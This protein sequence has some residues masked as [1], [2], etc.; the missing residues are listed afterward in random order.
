MVNRLTEFIA[1]TKGISTSRVIYF[2]KGK[3]YTY[4]TEQ[5]VQAVTDFTQDKK[6]GNYFK[7]KTFKIQV[8]EFNDFIKEYK[9]SVTGIEFGEDNSIKIKTNIPNINLTFAWDKNDSIKLEKIKKFF[10][11]DNLKIYSENKIFDYTFT[12]EELK[13][14]VDEKPVR[15][16]ADLDN[17]CIA[18]NDENLETFLMIS[19]F[20]K[21]LGKLLSSTK[22][23]NLKIYSTDKESIFLI[24]YM[25]RNMNILS[26]YFGLCTDLVPIKEGG[27]D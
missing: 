15:M 10:D 9:K 20:P 12:D 1:Q 7:D 14:Y 2:H 5:L 21:Y 23:F 6:G 16:F 3:S 4:D 17:N 24:H 13:K 22:L 27:L 25:I 18:F 19:I 8:D 26:E 11:I